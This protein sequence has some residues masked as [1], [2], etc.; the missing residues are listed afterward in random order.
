VLVLLLPAAARAAVFEVTVSDCLAPGGFKAAV[1]AANANPGADVINVA[2]GLQVDGASCGDPA[3]RLFPVEVTGDVT[4][5]ANEATFQGVLEFVDSGGQVN[6]PQTICPAIKP[7]DV[8]VSVTGGFLKVSNGA[9]VV[10]RKALIDQYQALAQVSRGSSL[11]L[12]DIS[13]T[14]IW[15]IVS[16]GTPAIESN[17]GAVAL[18][19]VFF[20]D[21]QNYGDVIPA[22]PLF[23]GPGSIAGVDGALNIQDSTFEF[24]IGQGFITWLGDAGPTTVNVVSS[25]MYQTGGLTLVGAA[26]GNVVNS[27]WWIPD[28]FTAPGFEDRMQNGGQGEMTFTASTLFYG[29]IECNS[30]C[31]SYNSPP[32]LIRTDTG[33]VN[34]RSSAIATNFPDGAELPY[35]VA[36]GFTA[37]AFTWIRTTNVQN[38]A[39][40]IAATGQTGLLTG[41][42]GL[43]SLL[44]PDQ[45]YTMITPVAGG[46]LIAAVPDAQTTNQL[47]NPIDGQPI[48]KDIFGSPRTD[49]STRDTGAVQVTFAPVLS[50]SGTGDGE[51]S[52]AWTRPPNPAGGGTVTGYRVFSRLQGSSGPWTLALTVMVASELTGVV[53]GLTNGQAYEFYVSA[54]IDNASD[55]P[56]SNTVVGTPFG[57]M[58][59]PVPTVATGTPSG[60]IGASWPPSSTGGRTLDHYTITYTPVGGTD[61]K[62]VTSNPPTVLLSQLPLKTAYSVCVTAVATDGTASQPGCTVATS[63]PAVTL[64]LLPTSQPSGCDFATITADDLLANPGQATSIVPALPYKA[65][66]GSYAFRITVAGGGSFPVDVTVR[67]C[68]PRCQPV[69]LATSPGTCEA[70]LD[71]TAFVTP[72]TVGES[73]TGIALTPN[74]NPFAVG[75]TSTGA[76]VT[77]AGGITAATASE[78][79]VTVVDGERPAIS[80]VDRCVSPKTHAYPK[81]RTSKCFKASELATATDN[82]GTAGD[83]VYSVQRCSAAGS[84]S[85]KGGKGAK[86]PC[87]VR[88][89]GAGVCVSLQSHASPLVVKVTVRATDAASNFAQTVSTIKVYGKKQSGGGAGSCTRV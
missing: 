62:A 42:P 33:G 81:G 67:P 17:G 18:T 1:D 55:G 22:I 25:T 65:I 80:P 54:T 38:A 20:K 73:S 8:I 23:L 56:A 32:L 53:S 45:D 59:T 69:T 82:C 10:V 46:V 63:S 87:S 47:L 49:G 21:F 77:Y 84:G 50:L 37:D 36:P 61:G 28:G 13:A 68:V 83:L 70:T 52:L 60:T 14:R 31:R 40:L 34:F 88:D 6:P 39:A 64:Q 15:S 57:S 41:L 2:A 48:L 19:R 79:T 4:I 66:P 11:T 29:A 74:G 26:S 75:Q 72:Q 16:C 78:C 51:V 9:R 86:A 43:P 24:L 35:F 12:E 5:E 58:A 7:S 27:A 89:D 76:V 3:V 30:A 85:S 71:P 44:G